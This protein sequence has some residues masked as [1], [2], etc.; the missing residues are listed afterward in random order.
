MLTDHPRAR[1]ARMS[2]SPRLAA[3]ETGLT[4]NEV[5]RINSIRLARWRHRQFNDPLVIAKNSRPYRTRFAQMAAL[6][7]QAERDNARFDEVRFEA[8]RTARIDDIR[9]SLVLIP[10]VAKALGLA[11][12]KS[13]DRRSRVSSYYLTGANSGPAIRISDHEI[14]SNPR[15]EFMA[16]ENGRDGHDGYHGHEIVIDRPRSYTWLKRAVL[17]AAN[18]RSVP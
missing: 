13:T 8:A 10:R 9:R 7:D 1:A 11:C 14:P 15:R 4:E 3:R 16:R 17:L 18:G 6:L 2:S 12:R 5:R